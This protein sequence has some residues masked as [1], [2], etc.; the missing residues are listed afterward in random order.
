LCFDFHPS[1]SSVYLIGTGEGHI[2]KCSITNRNHY[3]ETYQKHFGAVNHIDRSPFYPDVFLSCSYDWTIQ[4]WKEKTLTPILGFSS[5]QRSVVTVRWSPHQ[6]DVFAAING[7]QMEIW[8]LNTNILNP[9]IVH[10]A[11]P[12]VEFTSLLF[13]RATDYVLVGD[14]DGEVTVYQLRNLRVD[15]YSNLTNHT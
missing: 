5:S 11:A 12:G 2:H 1:D 3:L 6:P 8:D 15:S 4:L 7:Q 9:I 10:R 13:A 14:S